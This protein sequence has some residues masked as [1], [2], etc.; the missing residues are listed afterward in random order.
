MVAMQYSIHLPDTFDPALIKKR[1]QERSKL[2]DRLPGLIHKSF[3]YSEDEKIYA[4][5]YIWKDQK[6]ARQFLLDDLFKGV[7]DTFS[8]PRVRTWS[9]LSTAYGNKDIT[10]AFALIEADSISPDMKLDKLVEKE[11]KAQAQL[12]ENDDL[13]F[14]AIA[15]DAD[16]W[17]IVHYGLWKNADTA[18]FSGGDVTHSF[19]VLHLSE[20]E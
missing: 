14:H 15:L 4:P 12:V 16:R 10:P 18:I 5:F 8:R 3:L 9:V 7:I 13:Y 6:S 19:E 2:F 17:E 20:P 11:K 1:V